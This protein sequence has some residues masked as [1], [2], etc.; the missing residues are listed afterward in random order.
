M[1][2]IARPRMEMPIAATGS[3]KERVEHAL[4]DL[5]DAVYPMDL[6]QAPAAG[7][8]PVFQAAGPSACEAPGGCCGLSGACADPLCCR[9]KV[10]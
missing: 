6:M 7:E 8:N 10:I 4:D 1:I 5:Q 3:S 9:E 2:I